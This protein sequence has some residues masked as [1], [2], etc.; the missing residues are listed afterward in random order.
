MPCEK[1]PDAQT[2]PGT[3]EESAVL[4]KYT[5]HHNKHHADELYDLANRLDGEARERVHAAVIDFERGNRKL[6]EALS[7]LQKEG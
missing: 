2:E 3:L 7:L 6:E 4:L 1:C 5:I